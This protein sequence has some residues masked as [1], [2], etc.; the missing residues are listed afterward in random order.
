MSKRLRTM[1]LLYDIQH[2]SL[3]KWLKE[4]KEFQL[5][6]IFD[7]SVLGRAFLYTESVEIIKEEEND[8]EFT[9]GTNSTYNVQ[10]I[11]KEHSVYGSCTCP[12]DGKCKHLA[13]SLLVMINPH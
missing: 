6:S 2:D 3:Q 13:A 1:Y 7:T 12:Y 9:V 11:L 5:D 10:L 8:L 4:L